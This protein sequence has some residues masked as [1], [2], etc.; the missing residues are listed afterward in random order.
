MDLPAASILFGSGIVGGAL[1]GL[2]G[3]ASLITFPALLAAG[4]SPVTAAASNLAAI[5]PAN[6]IAA[7]TDRSQTPP[8][9]RA[10]GGLIV[11]SVLGALIGA[12]LLMLTPS[13]AFEILVPVLLGFATVLL[14]FS[15]QISDWIRARALA[16]G[17]GDLTM[18]VTSLPVLLP[19]SVYGGY[20]GAGVGVILLGVLSVVT[21]GDYRSA[22]VIKNLVTGINTIVAVACFALFGAV[23][24]PAALAMGAGALLGGLMGGHLARVVSPKLMRIAVV[25]LGA[26]LTA[27]YAWRYWF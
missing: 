24:W 16:H 7:W 25:V 1:A 10:F 21:E 19:I 23:D 9:G 12:A 17:K 14:A 20:F 15:R 5:A 26:A 22:N 3:G 13:R 27:I 11:A 4:L 2:V 8:V 6:F 18:S